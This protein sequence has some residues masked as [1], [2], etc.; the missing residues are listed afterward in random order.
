ME[1]TTGGTTLLTPTDAKF[2]VGREYQPPSASKDH[3]PHGP[4]E[5]SK[6]TSFVLTLTER[7]PLIH[8]ILVEKDSRRIFYFMT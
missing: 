6:F 5:R 1:S 7:W 8:T 3:V 4:I 2:D